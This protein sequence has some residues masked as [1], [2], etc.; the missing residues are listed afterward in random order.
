MYRL[1]IPGG[2]AVTPDLVHLIVSQ[3]ETAE[4]VFFDTLTEK[5]TD[6][7][8]MDFQ[9]NAMALRDDSLFV[10]AKGASSVYELSLK[11]KKVKND[12]SI[13]ADG[14]SRIA[15]HPK[16]PLLF[17]S[18]LNFEVYGIDTSSGKSF[19]TSAMGDH[20]AVS[21]DGQSLYTGMQPRSSNGVLLIDETPDGKIR[22]LFDRWGIRSTLA[23]YKISG[24][25]L[26]LASSQANATV[27]G[28]MMHLSPDG[29]RLMI[30]GGGGWRP[31][32]EAGAGGGYVTAIFNAEN[33]SAKLGQGPHAEAVVYHPVLDFAAA[34]G[35]G[36][37]LVLFNGKSFKER[38]T[39][40]FSQGGGGGREVLAFVGKGTKVA[41]FN[42]ANPAVNT[43]GL[44][45]FEIDLTKE[46]RARLVKE[47]GELPARVES[48]AD[49]E[50]PEKPEPSQKTE[51]EEATAPDARPDEPEDAKPA[52][53]SKKA[54]GAGK[55]PT[56][57]A[58]GFND[59]KG[60][61][62]NGK[63]SSPYALGGP[64]FQAGAGE[65][66]WE[67]NWAVNEKVKYQKDVV[68]EGDGALFL[69]NAS[70]TNRKLAIPY[71]GQVRLEQY[72]QIPENGDL[73]VYC[74]QKQDNTAAMWLA[75]DGKFWVINGT[76]MQGSPQPP[77][78]TQIACVPGQ[79]YKVT[80]DID[81]K[82]RTWTFA[83][84]DA[85][86]EH[87]P[88]QFRGQSEFI[89]EIS[90][91]SEKPGGAYIDAIT[92]SSTGDAGT[93]KEPPTKKEPMAKKEPAAK[94]GSPKKSKP[95]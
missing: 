10:T 71:T 76:G 47:Y 86:Y 6:R 59:A 81:F 3:P 37:N 52:A 75:T 48:V 9:P 60:I 77:I 50:R 26:S 46:E 88:L 41:L 58:A 2:F 95:N 49:A 63:K 93:K 31:P 8:E 90:L 21:P 55:K 65:P 22:F 38:E 25:K 32:A 5:E 4:L 23:R 34:A 56:E 27:N 1:A 79:W 53:K 69:S 45:F 42:G 66:G 7:L 13:P 24:Q 43:E 85:R 82:S 57:V 14:I 12:F 87:A 35:A 83:V 44:H 54:G 11:T 18:T 20:L 17:V 33:L 64:N 89:Q 19:K 74:D 16:K 70:N 72:V 67:S 61:N 15:A 73:K 36:H 94:K 68:Q 78:D 28:W 91:L 30:T 62:S 29:K 51:P 80:V 92:I 84:D 40:K 39:I